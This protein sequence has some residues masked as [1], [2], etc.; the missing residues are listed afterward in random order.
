V[1]CCAAAR[2]RGPQAVDGAERFEPTMKI[3]SNAS[4]QGPLAP[5]EVFPDPFGRLYIE[6]RSD[7]PDDTIGLLNCTVTPSGRTD[8]TYA[9]D[10][11]E[12]SCPVGPLDLQWHD[13]TGPSSVR[14]SIQSFKFAGVNRASVVCTVVRC[15]AQEPCG[16]CAQPGGGPATGERRLEVE[17][18]ALVV[19][20]INV[21]R[22]GLVLPAPVAADGPPTVWE[23]KAAAQ[24]A[25]EV[26][27][28]SDSNQRGEKGVHWAERVAKKLQDKLDERDKDTT[29]QQ[30]SAS[31]QRG[32]KGVHWAE[33]VAKKLQDK[34]D[35]RDKDTTVQQTSA[36]NQRGEKGVHW[37]ERVAKKLQD[38]LDERGKDKSDGRDEDAIP[39]S[40]HRIADWHDV[41]QQSDRIGAMQSRRNSRV[42]RASW[43][44]PFPKLQ[45]KPAAGN[46]LF[47]P[48]GVGRNGRA[49]RILG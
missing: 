32:E 16:V 35:E 9:V 34:L 5:D 36:S 19:Q 42:L 25:A 39:K 46:S 14:V 44:T 2:T 43:L 28:A 11:L 30:T 40:E 26:Q 31:N 7:T 29:V 13:T 41:H 10:V 20:W 12:D 17:D 48:P 22:A 3:F 8:D 47:G 38:K 37:A 33:R 18:R 21:R 1:V 27:Q 6:V 15:G 49:V 24:R 23:A 4:F 45:G